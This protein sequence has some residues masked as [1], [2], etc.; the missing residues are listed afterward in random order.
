MITKK[1]GNRPFLRS[2]AD[3]RPPRGPAA[4]IRSFRPLFSVSQQYNS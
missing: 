2:Y 3:S 4:D 1:A